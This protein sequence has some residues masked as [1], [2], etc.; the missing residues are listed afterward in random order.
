MEEISDAEI[1]SQLDPLKECE[2]KY[3]FSTNVGDKQI[4][5]TR[6][7]FYTDTL[8]ITTYTAEEEVINALW[9]VYN[10]LNNAAPNLIK[11]FIVGSALFVAWPKYDDR[12]EDAAYSTMIEELVRV[13]AFFCK[14]FGVDDATTDYVKRYVELCVAYDRK[15][16]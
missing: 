8:Y 11:S 16:S 5:T 7:A 2:N 3:S 10:V 15:N 9:E 14:E 1:M 12:F 4:S 6:R 13:S